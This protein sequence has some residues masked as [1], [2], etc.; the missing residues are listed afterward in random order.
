MG[1]LLEAAAQVTK[2]FL[3]L[4]KE[5]LKS[6]TELSSLQGLQDN[7]SMPVNK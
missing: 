6:A 3:C 4:T 7:S 2:T 1:A 5:V